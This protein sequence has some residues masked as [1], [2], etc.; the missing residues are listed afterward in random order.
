MDVLMEISKIGTGGLIGGFFTWLLTVQNHR[1]ET[2]TLRKNQSHELDKLA[3]EHGN[4]IEKLKLE[5]KNTVDA[6]ERKRRREVL[7]ECG[8]VYAKH[9]QWMM[10][11]FVLLNSLST[12]TPAQKQHYDD[13]FS[14]IS[15]KIV[16]SVTELNT[17]TAILK[18]NGEVVCV[19]AYDVFEEAYIDFSRKHKP[20][21]TPNYTNQ[22][23]ADDFKL[24]LRA[25]D[26]LFKELSES[27]LK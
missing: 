12:S 2:E 5:Q 1:K 6:D 14:E 10:D 27:Y 8:T 18:L 21:T 26:I 22:K 13:K 7:K 19:A 20:S 23:R 15:T 9:Y 3:K 25:R 17:C 16:N 11:Y 24:V 4:A